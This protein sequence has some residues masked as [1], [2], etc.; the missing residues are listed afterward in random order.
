MKRT[1]LTRRGPKQYRGFTWCRIPLGE[2]GVVS[3]RLFRRDYRGA[4]HMA[5]LNFICETREEIA[6]AVKRRRHKLRDQVDEI[7]LQQWDKA[8]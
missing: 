7:D 8:A 1:H 3:Y 5:A 2:T 6:A 4:L